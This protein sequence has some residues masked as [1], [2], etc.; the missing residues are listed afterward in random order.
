MI[1]LLNSV[2]WPSDIESRIFRFRITVLE[3]EAMLVTFFFAMMLCKVNFKHGTRE[4]KHDDVTSRNKTLK[5]NI[6]NFF[7]G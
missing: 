4:G 5:A 3:N 2:F 7:S 6:P 1:H